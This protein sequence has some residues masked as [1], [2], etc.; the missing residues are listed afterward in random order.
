MMTSRAENARLYRIEKFSGGGKPL[1]KAI[2]G[3]L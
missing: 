2:N 3:F 1:Q